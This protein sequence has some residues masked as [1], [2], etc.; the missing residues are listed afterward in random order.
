MVKI[1]NVWVF[2]FF[3][4]CSKEHTAIRV[5]ILRKTAGTFGRRHVNINFGGYLV[6]RFFLSCG[7]PYDNHVRSKQAADLKSQYTVALWLDSVRILIYE[8]NTAAMT[9]LKYTSHR[10]I[11]TQRCMSLN[12]TWFCV[13]HVSSVCRKRRK[14]KPRMGRVPHRSND[15]HTKFRKYLLKVQSADAQK[16][17]W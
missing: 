17:I 11:T 13:R 5:K 16:A 4:D 6:C 9:C 10:F 2:R 15:R 14:K 12:V 3:K 8:Q 1:T 7:Q